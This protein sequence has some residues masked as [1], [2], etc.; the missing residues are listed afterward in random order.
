MQRKQTYLFFVFA[1]LAG[2]LAG[3]ALMVAASKRIT[4]AAE[5]NS[6]VREALS[7]FSPEPVLPPD[8]DGFSISMLCDRSAF[9]YFSGQEE[10]GG[11]LARRVW[12]RNAHLEAETGS[13][14]NTYLTSDFYADATADILSGD[15]VYNLYAADAARSLSKLLAAGHLVDTSDSAYI[16]QT[17]PWY[18]QN[19]MDELSLFGQRFLISSS[20]LDARSGATVLLYNRSLLRT[21]ENMEN[22][23]MS[24]SASALDGLFTLEELLA[25]SKT[26]AA[27]YAAPAS[28][29]TLLDELTVEPD[30]AKESALRA[31][32]NVLYEAGAPGDDAAFY[33][34]SFGSEHTF[35]LYSALGG[36]FAES[37]SDTPAVSVSLDALRETLSGVISL[38]LEAS[39]TVHSSAFENAGALFGVAKLSEIETV[40]TAI[41]DIGLLPMPKPGEKDEYRCFVDLRGTPVMA[42]PDGA[43]DMD[44]LEYLID[45]MAFLSYGYIE[46]LL[47]QNL[48]QGNP[49]DMQVLELIYDSAIYD[50]ANLFGYGSI[51]RLLSDALEKGTAENLTLDYYNRQ[52]LYE[53]AFEIIGKRL[54]KPPDA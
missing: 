19:G 46:P 4:G 43:A 27:A 42:I 33:G 9:S 26:A 2:L 18:D 13:T 50:L 51:E 24:L 7:V 53:K 8:T 21:L 35:A 34:L 47:R 16:R 30:T 48:T 31:A 3:A 10:E 40:K 12:L 32:S 44:K 6:E 17:L 5:K 38:S 49:D 36:S 28:A 15:R 1:V 29:P 41:S 14:L 37:T 11:A 45:R 23:A 54:S 52:T 25:V 39:V 22:T 20:A